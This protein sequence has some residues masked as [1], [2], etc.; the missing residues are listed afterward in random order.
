[1]K[2]SFTCPLPPSVNEYLGKRVSYNPVTRKPFVQVYETTE[3]KGFK[4]YMKKLIEREVIKKGW[5]KTGEYEYVI[6][7]VNVFLPQKKRD[8]DNLFK[9]L[10]DSFTENEIIYDDSMVIPRVKEVYIDSANPRLEITLYKADKI[11]V[12][13]DL[14]HLEDFKIKNCYNCK[15][16]KRNCSLLRQSTENRIISEIDFVKM[17]CNKYNEKSSLS[18]KES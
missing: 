7:E 18:S 6:C 17:E 2:V 11:G 8:C 14:K 12:F 15:R 3:A 5:V 13:K 1:M 16:L 10:L 9:C 4:R